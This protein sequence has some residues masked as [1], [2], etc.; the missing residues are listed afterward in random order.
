MVFCYVSNFKTVTRTQ[1][2]KHTVY[3]T[4]FILV[5]TLCLAVHLR[6]KSDA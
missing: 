4:A 2:L 6:G 1:L 5:I 3:M